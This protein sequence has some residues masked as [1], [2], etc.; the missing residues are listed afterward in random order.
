M[1]QK[2]SRYKIKFKRENIHSSFYDAALIINSTFKNLSKM[3]NIFNEMIL[4]ENVGKKDVVLNY[5]AD[6]PDEKGL[7]E[8][9]YNKHKSWL[10][11]MRPN[12]YHDIYFKDHYGI[13]QTIYTNKLNEKIV[14]NFDIGPKS[15]LLLVEFP[16]GFERLFDWYKNFMTI[17]ITVF[18]PEYGGLYPIVMQ[19]LEPPKISGGWISFFNKKMNISERIFSEYIKLPITENEFMYAIEDQHMLQKNIE[20]FRK[21]ENLV[22]EFKALNYMV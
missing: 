7:S 8:L 3:D 22:N 15:N 11:K 21:L 9:L 13:P 16:I 1:E 19:K 10:N 12:V 20:Q 6:F 17:L 18:K 14:F 4:I 5:R 2:I